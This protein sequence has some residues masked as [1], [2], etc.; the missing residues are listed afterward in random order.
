MEGDDSGVGMQLHLGG[1]ERNT[2]GANFVDNVKKNLSGHLGD[3]RGA[4]Q[5]LWDIVP[6]EVEVPVPFEFHRYVS[7]DTGEDSWSIGEKYEVKVT[8]PPEDQQS[9]EIVIRG[10]PKNVEAARHAIV[11]KVVE[12]QVEKAEK[13]INCEIFGRDSKV[14]DQTQSGSNVQTAKASS[15]HKTNT[16]VIEAGNNKGKIASLDVA[17][18][19]V[20][21]LKII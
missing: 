10:V 12:L 6:V 8:V 18:E 14:I 19:R 2:F 17:K 16:T 11:A 21:S 20:K 4:K 13:A 1:S 15:P 7:S 3:A 9:N 5:A